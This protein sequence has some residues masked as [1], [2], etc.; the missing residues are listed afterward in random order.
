MPDHSTISVPPAGTQTAAEPPPPG[1]DFAALLAVCPDSV[2]VF[3]RDFRIIYA[4]PRAIRVSHLGADGSVGKCYWD[5]RPDARGSL[6]EENFLGAMHNRQP[7]RFEYFYPRFDLW[8]DVQVFPHGD[9]L[10]AFYKDVTASKHAEQNRDNATRQLEHLY[11]TMPDAILVLDRNWNFTFANPLAIKLLHSGGLV[12]ENIWTLFPARS[13]KSLSRRTTAWRWSSACRPSSRPSIRLRFSR[14]YHVSVRPFAD[15][16]ITLFFS[17]IT[18]RKATEER[19]DELIKRLDQV[20]ATTPDSIL[21]LDANWNF[22]FANPQA[23]ELLHSGPLVGENLWTLFP[24]NFEEP[25]NSNYH[26]TMEERIPTEFE[27]F[28]PDPLNM[29]FRVLARPYGDDCLIVFFRDITATKLLEQQRDRN[30]AQLEQVFDVTTDSIVSLDRNYDITFLNRRAGELLSPVGDV[31]GKNLWE[32]FPGTLYEGSPYQE[33]YCR[34]MDER[35]P[36]H[37]EAFYPAPLNFWLSIEAQPS[38]EGI[39]VFFRDITADRLAADALRAS[40]NRYR[41]LTELNPQLIF[42]SDPKGHITFA[43]QSLLDFIGLPQPKPGLQSSWLAAIHPDDQETVARRWVHALKSGTKYTGVAR[44]CRH[45]DNQYRWLDMTALPIRDPEG[46]IQSWLGV[47]SDIHDQKSASE[48]LTASESRYRIL[49]DLNPQFI[50]MGTHDGQVSYAN[51][52]FL[53]YI[54]P[55]HTPDDTGKWINAFDPADRDRVIRAWTHSVTTGTDYDIEAR[56]LRNADGA[57]RWFRMRASPVRDDAGNI[58]HWLGVAID[59]H[60]SRTFAEELHKKQLETERQRAE[61]ESI[62]ENTPVG[63]ALFDPV[64]F[65]YLRINDE[66]ARSIGLPKEQILGRSI[67]EIASGVATIGELFRQVATGKP[68]RDYILEGE[69]STQPG[70]HRTW[71]VNY[72]PVYDRLG[73]ITG[74]TTASL[75]I[76]QQRKTE[77]ALVQSEKLAAV[78]RLASSISHEI[79]NPLEAITN[80]L[81][82]VV[83]SPDLPEDLRV[84]VNMAQSE[85]SR[86]SQIAT[87]TLRFHRQA[88]K[89]TSV[90]AAQLVDAVLNLYQGRLANSGI[91]VKARYNSS[92]EILCFENDI[93]QVLNNLIANAIDA[94][95]SGGRLLIRAHDTTDRPTGRRGIR[96]TIA[97]TGHGMSAKTLSRLYEP[98]YTTKDL[99][100]T[101][102]GLWISHGIVSRHKGRLHVRSTQHPIHHGTIFNLFLP[103]IPD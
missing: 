90:T 34:A 73:N 67:L 56:L 49:T 25:Y 12:G 60:E 31:L 50:W 86:V 69:L 101:G 19:R 79:N 93:R 48:A 95:R 8:V 23:V 68:I 59:M 72:F 89:P 10:A 14:W 81:Y 54:G 98:F 88:V 84:Y 29:W 37:F 33:H 27:A 55:Q 91:T 17:D 62:Y 38:A 2:I 66:L 28:Y 87:Q 97:D 45:I 42:T 9:G 77:A 80:L 85:L 11:A 82:L 75:E 39:I 26:R 35:I 1:P 53:E 76:T 51:Q 63:L 52:R 100:G 24:G 47:A 58:L 65:R 36:S 13:S 44:I 18:V 22:N 102:L 61:L 83:L 3:D 96:V 15:D 103:C 57:S 7:R 4:N 99:N 64:T 46:T 94:M 5:L 71:N 78:G 70:V 16:G 40:E 6:L 30:A 21:I 92:T 32:M 41:I 74:I 20:Y 43:N